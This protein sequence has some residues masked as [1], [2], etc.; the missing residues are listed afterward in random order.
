[1]QRGARGVISSAGALSLVDVLV[2]PAERKLA[3]VQLAADS[4][5]AALDAF[6]C[7]GSGARR[8]P[9]PARGDAAR[10]VV[11]IQLEVDLERRRESVL[12][13]AAAQPRTHRPT[14]CRSACE[15]WREPLHVAQQPFNSRSCSRPWT[16]AAVRSPCPTAYEAPAADCQKRRPC[17][18]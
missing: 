6:S 3:R 16:S 10:D 11:G 5:Q 15:L 9:T 17:R 14:A 18:T 1:M 2:R 13:R 8:G 12:V 7:V 4:P